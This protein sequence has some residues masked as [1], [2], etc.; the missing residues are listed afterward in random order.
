MHGLSVIDISALV[1]HNSSKMSCMDIGYVM[2][3]Y[4][5]HFDSFSARLH[6]RKAQFTRY[7]RSWVVAKLFRKN[8]LPISK[9]IESIYYLLECRLKSLGSGR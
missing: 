9:V 8:D 7:E 3:K 2:G 6:E 4:T 1:I 5:M